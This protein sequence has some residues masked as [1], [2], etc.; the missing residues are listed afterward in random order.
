V[1][2]LGIT[3]LL[4]STFKSTKKIKIK[5]K[6]I[7]PETTSKNRFILANKYQYSEVKVQ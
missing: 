7:T 2:D 5:I 3:L 6:I 4:L 1:Q